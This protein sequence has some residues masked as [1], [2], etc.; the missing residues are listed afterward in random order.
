MPDQTSERTFQDE[1]IEHLL[2]NGWLLG[3]SKNYNREL[4]LYEE[5]L[6][7]FVQESQPEQWK[8]FRALYPNNA[9]AKF[10]ERV[11]AQLNKADPNAAD[12]AMRTFGT[13][14]V[15]RHAIK[16]RGTRFDLCQFKPEHD[17][18]PDTLERYQ[19]NRLRVVPELVYSPWTK[20]AP[21]EGENAEEPP[22]GVLMEMPTKYNAPKGITLVKIE[23]LAHRPRAFCEWA[24][25]GDAG[26]EVGIQASSAKG[27]GAVSKGPSPH[28]SRDQKARAAP[29]LQARCP[30]SLC[31][32][33]V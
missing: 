17:L 13:L 10:V 25:G 30:R 24:P 4:A 1:I 8:K 21:P 2:A 7:G 33:P 27:D 31:G 18:N 15:L 23:S 12:S 14:G 29:D 26:A 22:K 9:E 16:D 19:K 3:T 32:E 20:E 28:R 6:L 5:D 11:A